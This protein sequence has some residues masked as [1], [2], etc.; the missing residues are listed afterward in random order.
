[1]LSLVLLIKLY[2]VVLGYVKGSENWKKKEIQYSLY[3]LN[4]ITYLG[5]CIKYMLDWD[6]CKIRLYTNDNYS[7]IQSISTTHRK[8]YM[9]SSV[10][11]MS[12]YDHCPCYLFDL[13][14]VAVLDGL[15]SLSEGKVWYC[16]TD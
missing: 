10:C 15:Q 9:L 12:M 14:G 7:L 2:T 6:I 11:L 1:M 3:Y 4:G 16:M 5:T 13:S 8:K